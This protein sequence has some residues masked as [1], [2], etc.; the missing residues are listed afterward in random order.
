MTQEKQKLYVFNLTG[1][2][3]EKEVFSLL[4]NILDYCHLQLQKSPDE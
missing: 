2:R 3:M 1:K 4:V